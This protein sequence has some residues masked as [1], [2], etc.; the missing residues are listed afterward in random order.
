[1]S[2]RL[3]LKVQG[4]QPWCGRNGAEA[5]ILVKEAGK[6]GRILLIALL[7][8]GLAPLPVFKQASNRKLFLLIMIGLA[9]RDG[10]ELL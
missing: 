1:M 6:R 3:E 2:V 5:H 8:G 4:S 7:T 10:T 9:M